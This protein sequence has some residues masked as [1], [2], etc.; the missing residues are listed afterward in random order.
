MP[1]PGLPHQQARIIRPNGCANCK[2]KG[3]SQ[4][5]G[6]YECR[7]YPPTACTFMVNGGQGFVTHTGW[8]CV[9]ADGWCGEWGVK[10]EIAN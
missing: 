8:P 1:L 7:R 3:D 5:P 10:V 2:H 4:K 9:A 6:Q